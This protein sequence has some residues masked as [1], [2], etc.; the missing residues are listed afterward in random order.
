MFSYIINEEKIKYI[1]TMNKCKRKK[2]TILESFIISLERKKNRIYHFKEIK[3]AFT[4]SNYYTIY[5]YV[6]TISLTSNISLNC[7]K[8]LRFLYF[9]FSF[10]F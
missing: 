1:S 10:F 4:L 2:L 9:L 5:I 6:D 7:S 8:C 3:Y